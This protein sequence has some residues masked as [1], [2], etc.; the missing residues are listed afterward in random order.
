MNSY[1]PLSI[2]SL[3]SF[4]DISDGAWTRRNKRMI[5]P[6]AVRC[7]QHCTIGQGNVTILD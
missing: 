5:N 6:V 7:S 4:S 3:I 1:V 2:C